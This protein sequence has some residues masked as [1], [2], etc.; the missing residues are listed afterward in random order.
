MP[1]R[2]NKE[3]LLDPNAINQVLQEFERIVGGYTKIKNK[4]KSIQLNINDLVGK[5]SISGE[6]VRQLNE[7]TVKTNNLKNATQKLNEQERASKLLDA[8]LAR[9]RAKLTALDSQRG[10]EL[11]KLK[12]A[13][14]ELNI[15][16][17]RDLGFIGK[18][19]NAFKG[20]I[21]QLKSLVITYLSLYGVLR[22]VNS[23]FTTTKQLE[24][25]RFSMK[26]VITDTNELASTQA[27]LR[28]SV[29]DLGLELIKTTES[30]VRFRATT[31]N[32]N[33]SLKDTRDIFYTVAKAGAVLGL[34]TQRIELA[35]LALEQMAS[36]GT[37][38]ME[39]LRRQLG[40]QLP[41]AVTILANSLK[42]PIPK[43]YEL[44]KANKILADETLPKLAQG[45]KDAYNLDIV[46]RVD[47]LVAAQN[48]LTTAWI[49]F[50]DAIKLSPA[51]KES[52]N[53]FA[54]FLNKVGF[55]QQA[56][57]ADHFSEKLN[58]VLESLK[59]IGET[60]DEEA[61]R[62]ALI[63]QWQIASEKSKIFKTQL[64]S[65]SGSIGAV[66]K[67]F[68]IYS[69]ENVRDANISEDAI[70]TLYLTYSR[71]RKELWRLL[72]SYDE[73]K[74][75]WEKPVEKK[76][77]DEE[78]EK[79]EQA[80]LSATGIIEKL[81][82]EL[83]LRQYLK[84]LSTDDSEIAI[85]NQRI[86]KISVLLTYYNKLGTQLQDLTDYYK[87]LADAEKKF[88]TDLEAERKLEQEYRD[89]QRQAYFDALEDEEERQ[90]KHD[91]YLLRLVD[92]Y[93]IEFKNRRK[94]GFEE[95]DTLLEE[96][97]IT[98]KE[99]NFRRLQLWIRNNEQIIVLAESFALNVLDILGNLNAGEIN[100]L[101]E[102]MEKRE[103][104]VDRLEG[105]LN[106][107]EKLKEKGKANDVA[108]LRG[109]LEEEKVLRDKAGKELE[110]A[111]KREAQI[112]FAQ[113][114]G[115]IITA[116]AKLIEGWESA[117]P[118]FGWIIGIAQA[119]AMIA[120]YTAMK[121][122]IKAI[123]K[124][125]EGTEYLERGQNPKG[126]DTIPIYADEGERI[127]DKNTNRKLK[128][129]PNDKLPEAVDL[130]RLNF[131]ADLSKSNWQRHD[132]VSELIKEYR[133]QKEYSK[134][135][136][137][138]MEGKKDILPVSMTDK[139][140]VYLVIGKNGN[141]VRKRTIIK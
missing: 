63:T 28:K 30:Y 14:K 140:V 118:L 125:A 92:R 46:N 73:L 83:K 78:L 111:Q 105:L 65:I 34:S 98:E 75:F 23:V 15:E 109:Q 90:E 32:T 59:K 104:N 85:L 94:I 110:K 121:A 86:E 41:G 119:V 120:S 70:N 74:K 29:D 129:I 128:G 95:L 84:K 8:Q 139:E 126:K 67:N 38:S 47:T 18:R 49:K 76:A 100:L 36:K 66:A 24:S 108:R 45:F 72:G 21:T 35:L 3:I 102:E 80:F 138:L 132:N 114:S 107:E 134:R 11:Q 60:G 99:Y 57:D 54:D 68:N 81:E 116:T 1:G 6:G 12:Q 9:S 71:L 87:A 42:I 40:D 20:L 88:E 5:V 52:L 51:F 39:E 101:E 115:S 106:E 112:Q 137:E 62:A 58:D 4:I 69:V 25:L 37:I 122:K 123:G 31:K 22:L 136:V 44:I 133:E 27:F 56:H 77:I 33:L 82:A 10:K 141:D 96:H 2:I 55:S 17:K 79:L 117:N 64:D 48:R 26:T 91:E 131:N 13:Q 16:Q 43:M 61:V 50:V 93:N 7:L 97:L 127:V 103:D 89:E 19:S 124:Y 130:W 53:F 113:Q 135:M